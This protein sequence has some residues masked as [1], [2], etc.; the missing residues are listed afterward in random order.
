M[1]FDKDLTVKNYRTL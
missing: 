1:E